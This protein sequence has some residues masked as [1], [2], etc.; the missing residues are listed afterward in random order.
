M[1]FVATYGCPHATDMA[2]YPR[3]LGAGGLDDGSLALLRPW[4]ECLRTAV[5]AQPSVYI[6]MSLL[7]GRNMDA[8]S[9]SDGNGLMSVMVGLA[10]GGGGKGGEQRFHVQMSEVLRL[11][12]LPFEGGAG[13]WASCF[14]RYIRLLSEAGHREVCLAMTKHMEHVL[15]LAYSGYGLHA[16]CAQSAAHGGA[17]AAFLQYDRKKRASFEAEGGSVR[18]LHDLSS[19][20]PLT[21]SVA[22]QAADWEG[23]DK[24]RGRGAEKVVHHVAEKVGQRRPER[25][26]AAKG[27]E[28]PKA[29]GLCYAFQEGKCDYGAEACR[30]MHSCRTCGSKDHSEAKHPVGE[31][32]PKAASE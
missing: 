12:A 8:L 21:W 18:S 7:L 27:A 31:P 23:A 1:C 6:A 2:G 3:I 28:K 10:D 20:S 5:A 30:F 29:R 32:T 11:S 16:A 4:P 14:I 9:R 15:A 22:A 19:F 25:K 13:L 17:G 24:T 26:P